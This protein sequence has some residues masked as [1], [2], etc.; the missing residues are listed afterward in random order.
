[1][2]TWAKVWALLHPFV[3]MAL[4]LLV[5]H[6]AIKYAMKF[7]NRG[8][9]KSKLDPSLVKYCSKVVTILLY[10]FIILAA[11]DAVGV[12]TGGVI[13]AMS[14]GVVAVGVALRDSLSNV[15]GGVWL[16]FS[17]RFSTGDYIA[18]G[19]DE[20]TVISVDLLHTT[21]Q[22]FDGKQVSIPN[23]AL[24]NSHITNYS[25]ENKRRVD[26]LFPIAYEADVNQAKQL[27]MDTVS[28]HP[29]VVSEE[30][31]PFVRVAS[32]GESSV[33]LTVRAWCKTED[34][35][36]VFFDLTEQIREV[37]E[38]NNI[39]IP[40]NQLEVRIK[41]EASKAESGITAH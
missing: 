24:V 20:G 4:I 31:S 25:I 39:T 14:A 21:L 38:K 23:G 37:F 28:G 34:Y 30:K 19:G 27:A 7:I 1:M 33:N 29:L 40:Y 41:S 10:I 11:L 18:A 12:S 6:F 13:A 3:N 26:I 35:W 16:L 8:F 36:T 5:G 9:G 32:Y 17:P 22:T 15:A 2:L